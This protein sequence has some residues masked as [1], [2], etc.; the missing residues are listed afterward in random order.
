MRAQGKGS[1]LGL[2]GGW[3]AFRA[4]VI[5][6]EVKVTTDMHVT[7]HIGTGLKELRPVWHHS[8]PEHKR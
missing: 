2:A 8:N 7:H 4:L 1:E 3:L 6:R 5:D